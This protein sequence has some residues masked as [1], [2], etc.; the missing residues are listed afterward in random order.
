MLQLHAFRSPTHCTLLACTVS[1]A[2][3]Y[4]D[5]TSMYF[6]LSHR[7]AHLLTKRRCILYFNL[8]IE[9]LF[10]KHSGSIRA[11]FG[12]YFPQF[13]GRPYHS[14]LFVTIA[15]I[16]PNLAV[17]VR[18]TKFKL[19][20]TI[21]SETISSWH[22]DTAEHHDEGTYLDARLPTSWTPQSTWR[23]DPCNQSSHWRFPSWSRK[24]LTRYAESLVNGFHGS[25]HARSEFE[26]PQTPLFLTS[27]G[28]NIA[29]CGSKTLRWAASKTLSNLRE[30]CRKMIST[31]HTNSSTWIH[32][33]QTPAIL[34]P[35]S[36][37]CTQLSLTQLMQVED[38]WR[39]TWQATWQAT[40]P[41]TWHAGLI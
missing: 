38:S 26:P 1:T 37:Q 10:L 17:W 5:S 18:L 3:R 35:Y 28:I 24:T 14:A 9:L 4:S 19:W 32:H 15:R 31:L 39:M 11:L 27:W 6:N 34:T 7:S 8:V 33:F 22:H 23:N 41:V 40:W 36:S 2:S 16:E 29:N 30:M 25:S 13:R 12:L 20:E 21:C